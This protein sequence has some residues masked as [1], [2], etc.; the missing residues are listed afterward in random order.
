MKPEHSGALK[1]QVG[2]ARRRASAECRRLVTRLPDG[3]LPRGTA[4]TFRKRRSGASPAGA[5]NIGPDAGSRL[6]EGERHPGWEP[7]VAGQLIS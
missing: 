4:R 5:R 2:V 6:E 3:G 7:E 1:L